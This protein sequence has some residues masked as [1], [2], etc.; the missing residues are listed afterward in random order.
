M[1]RNDRA[2]NNEQC[3][4][5]LA[6]A[7]VCR[8]AL[9]DPKQDV[10]YIV[11]LTYGW[12][13][14]R[15]V[16]HAAVTGRKLELIRLGG[17][18]AFEIDLHSEVVAAEKACDWTVKFASLLGAG[19]VRILEDDVE[20]RQAL[21]VLMRHH[22]YNGDMELPAAALRGTAVFELN[23]EALSGKCNDLA[24]FERTVGCQPDKS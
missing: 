14:E 18:V 16:F 7:G 8:L 11:P 17:R 15:L 3:R 1:R 9:H 10:P 19:Q 12:Q 23:I 21:E 20:K 2:L 5:L 22:G 13:E 24:W 6:R 4:A